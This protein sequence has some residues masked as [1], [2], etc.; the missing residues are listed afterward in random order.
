LI[1]I[2]TLRA[3][4]SSAYGYER[5]TTPALETLA[6]QGV[7]FDAAYAPTATTGPTH[8]SLFTSLYPP[9]HRVIKNGRVLADEHETLAEVLTRWGYQCGAVVSS[10]VLHGKFNYGQ[11]F[12]SWNDDFSGAD[13]PIGVTVWE[14]GRIEGKFHG[15]ADDTTRRAI[16]WLESRSVSQPFFLFVH[17]FDPH[18]PY[19]PPARFRRR[20]VSELPMNERGGLDLLVASY[21][22]EIAYTDHM[23]EKLLAALDALELADE[24]LVVVTGDHGEGLM[25]HGHLNH[26]VH[27]Y[28]EAVRVPL[29]LRWPGRIAAG[30][31]IATPAEL[32]DVAPTILE[33]VRPGV[34]RGDGLPGGPIKVELAE[35]LREEGGAARGR[36]LASQI[37]QSTAGSSAASEPDPVYLYRRHYDGSMVGRMWTEGEQFG[38][39][40]GRWKYIR[41]DGSAS[42]QLFDLAADPGEQ[43]NLVEASADVA[44]QLSARLEAWRLSVSRNVEQPDRLQP[45]DRARLKALGY[46]D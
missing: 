32:T 39:R 24:T 46:A 9:T 34:Q 2:D 23:V 15:R 3:D 22:A 21:D 12:E 38:I 43:R 17:Y 5:A 13:T 10:Y 19:E 7:R 27:I 28:E 40:A 35:L 16:R 33:L 20:F 45:E 44:S 41:G 6:E 14:D 26:G 8:A 11:G 25:D 29:I 42:A 4:H 36:S 31:A 1:S 37:F 18:D 30:G